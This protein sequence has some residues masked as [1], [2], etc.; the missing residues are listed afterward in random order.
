MLSVSAT[1]RKPIAVRPVNKMFA[2][3]F[4]TTSAKLFKN[5]TILGGGLM[6]NG[7]TQVTA[8]A[9]YNVTMVD[10]NQELLNKSTAN[11][12]K[13][14]LRG[15]KK[16]IESGKMDEAS[17]KAKK[18]DIMSRIKG[19]VSA[20]EAAKDAD[21]VIEAVPENIAL[22]QKIFGSLDLVAPQHCVF[23]S[24][25]SSLKIVDIQATSK[26]ADRFA[27]VHFFNPVP[28]MKLLEVVRGPN[29]SEDTFQKLVE[30]GQKV[31]K[32]TVDCKD[33]PGFIVNRLLVPAIFEAI[34]LVERGDAS[35]EDVDTAMKLG[36]GHPMGPLALADMVGLDTCKN[37]LDGWHATYP[38]VELFQPSPLVNKLVSE[39][40]LGKKSGEGFYKY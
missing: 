1:M 37:I 28:V 18:D 7:I 5:V 22:K 3:Y 9:G 20:E 21:L 15:Y 10:V 17:A 19:M 38:D 4:S 26:R 16:A 31:G 35:K 12:E 27:G 8:A 33:T 36:A 11:I 34:R 25:T 40:K 39:G 2:A 13:T 29:T 6:G 23:A 24:N 32:T 30:Y 14:I